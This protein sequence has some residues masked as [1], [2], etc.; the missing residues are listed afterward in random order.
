MNAITAPIMSARE[1]DVTRLSSTELESLAQRIR[2]MKRNSTLILAI[3]VGRL[4]VEEIFGGRADMCT[5]SYEHPSFRQLASHP[6][7]PFSRATLW[8]YVGTYKV[9]SHVQWVVSNDFLTVAHI[10]AVA[11][12]SHD[13]QETLLRAAAVERWTAKRLT[14][15]AQG[16]ALVSRESDRERLSIRALVLGLERLQKQA[17]KLESDDGLREKDRERISRVVAE[18]RKWCDALERLVGA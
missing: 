11:G 7:V 14:N 18:T 5:S 1:R 17:F 3:D 2:H 6:E 10:S 9:A 8:R 15:E 12:L 13:R 16:T 4:I